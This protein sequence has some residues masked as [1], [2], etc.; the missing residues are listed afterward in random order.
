M[1]RTLF[2]VCGVAGAVA[3]VIMLWNVTWGY[4]DSATNFYKARGVDI[5]IVRAGVSNR[6][7]S[8]LRME[9][10]PL[11]GRVPRVDRVEGSLT[12]MVSLGEANLLGIPLRGIDP[13]G[14]VNE[15]LALLEGH[16][17]RP[18]G[19]SFVLVGSALAAAL[20]KHAGQAIEIE[21]KTFRI[22]GIFE[23][24]N[25]FDANSIIGRISE[26]QELM[27]RPET[28]SEFQVRVAPS[29]H[30]DG[31]QAKICRAIESLQDERGAPLG[32]KAQPTQQFV[33]TA[34][35]AKLTTA[36]AWATTTI[37][38]SL[39]L[40]GTLNTMLMSVM[41]RTRELGVLRAIGWKRSRLMRMILGESVVIS[42]LG[43]TI[44]LL[45][46]WILIAALSHWSR[47]S[48]LV[49]SHLSPVA[50]LLGFAAAILVGILGSFYPAFRAAS[51]R[52]VESLRSE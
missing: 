51:V 23:S 43:A 19:S 18:G 48:L 13:A 32:L 14:F 7:T 49:S 20:E 47:T 40:V 6:L 4:V 22:A 8:S 52:P 21:D 24:D 37:V 30:D 9:L 29:S 31:A 25:P 28:V 27:G 3:A 39:L 5:V 10:A 45:V 42:V 35:E 16:R 2:T 12:E 33:D 15:H 46:A 1:S 50:V 26:V 41:E 17:L 36:M 34:S 38:I 11:I 44:G